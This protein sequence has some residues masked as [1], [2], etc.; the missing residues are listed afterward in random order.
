MISPPSDSER[1]VIGVLRGGSDAAVAIGDLTPDKIDTL[2][3]CANDNGVLPLLADRLSTAPAV[4]S[5]VRE[6]CLNE[7]QQHVAI[8]LALE[9]ELR[10]VLAALAE[11]NIDGLVIK[12]SHLAYSHYQRPELRARVDADV[13]VRRE[14][15]DAAEGV[16]RTLGYLAAGK[17]TGELSA[18]QQLF[19]REGPG[20]IPL[21]IDLHWRWASPSAFAHVLSY[22]ELSAASVP[23]VQLGAAARGPSAVHALIVA[24]VHR[25]AHHQDEDDQLKWL[26]DIHLIAGRLTEREWQHF[27]GITAERAIVAVC[28]QGLERA[29]ERLGT[30]LPADVRAALGASAA[31]S[32]ELTAAYLDARS[33]AATV[34]TD[35]RALG[36]RDRWRLTLEHV[37]PSADYMRRSYA[38][39]S[40][41]PLPALYVLRFVR[42]ARSWLRRRA[43]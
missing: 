37:L 6:R 18:T 5:A 26:Y 28:G 2:F 41:L 38:P 1:L 36:W 9:T 39:G 21:R 8:D 25:V 14:Q 31:S 23:I 40:H 27:L 7:K 12:G 16:L 35:L 42:G 24:C 4:A 10:R 43:G 11:R 15:R 30:D 13:L 17:V 29:S 33:R 19:E 22:D 32:H 20:G 3:D 34:V